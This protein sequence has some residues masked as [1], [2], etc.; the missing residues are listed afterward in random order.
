MRPVHRSLFV[1]CCITLAAAPASS[2]P[3]AGPPTQV[4]I[5]VAT[6]SMAGMPDM[7]AMGGLASRM[8]GGGAM[9]AHYGQTRMPAMPG[10]YLDIALHNRLNPGKEAQQLVPAGLKLGKTLPL[11]PP[12]RKGE[13][14][15]HAGEYKPPEGQ[16]RLLIYWGCGDTV[17]KGQ[18]RVITLS[19]SGGKV[20]VSGSMQGRYAPDRTIDPDPAYALWPNPKS[21]KHV[22]DGASLQ[23]AH[24]VTGAGVPESLKFEL[25]Q[26]ADFMP[27][28]ALQ[29][30]GTLADGQTWRWSP[31]DRAQ[32]YF[33]HAIGAKGKDVVL[34][35]SAEVPDVG[36]GIV[37]Y[38]GGSLIE[39]WLKEKVL[40]PASATQCAI[41]KGIFA[42]A[43]EGSEG[44]GGLLSIIAYGPE[45]HIAW[46]P[47]P[48]DPKQPWNPEW[49]VRVRTKSTG[50]A[51]LGMDLSQ[52]QDME[53]PD[54]QKPQEE[55]KPLRRLLQ[56]IIGG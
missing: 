26:V 43:G 23:G 29:S 11:V 20:E 53:A 41:P 6:H 27:R 5:D 31:V 52:L 42:D 25:K 34:W 4:W 36:M 22:P 13:P 18:P 12:V 2:A 55:K 9:Q 38:L 7:G 14:V 33:L 56:G 48:A 45:S 35:S 30:S 8:M 24:Q 51:M 44:S 15:D 50:G 21:G 28:V 1:A 16:A 54:E 19:A 10:Q 46:P 32:A 39:R 17:R 47:K 37:D 3:P 40:L 49:N